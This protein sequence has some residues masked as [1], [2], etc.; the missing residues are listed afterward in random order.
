M[1][2]PSVNIVIPQASDFSFTYIS[3]NSDGSLKNL[4]GFTGESKL[5]KHS[6]SPTS[7]SF[8]VGINTITSVVSLAMTSGV[9]VDIKSGRYLYDVRITSTGGSVERILEGMAEVTAGITT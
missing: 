8:T 9:S 4:N 7:H 2:T 5:K 3:K 6:T 1:A